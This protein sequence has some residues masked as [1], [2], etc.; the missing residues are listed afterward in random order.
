MA[1]TDPNE[2]AKRAFV[3]ALNKQSPN[4]V[5]F[6]QTPGGFE[7]TP[8]DL[9]DR[10]FAG[11]GLNSLNGFKQELRDALPEIS[12]KIL[13][14]LATFV[15]ASK[16][17]GAFD[18]IRAELIKLKSPSKLAAKE[19]SNSSTASKGSKKSNKG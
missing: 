13:P 7:F 14:D 8:E 15:P 18:I 5:K 16:I 10:T 3:L 4:V 9:F 12:D 11:V 1:I 2:R 6:N 17:S 19:G